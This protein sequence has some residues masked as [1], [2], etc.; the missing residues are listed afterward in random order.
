[1]ITY[2]YESCLATRII[3][4]NIDLLLFLSILEKKSEISTYYQAVHS[5]TTNETILTKQ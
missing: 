3:I 4:S 5:S 2:D 1:M